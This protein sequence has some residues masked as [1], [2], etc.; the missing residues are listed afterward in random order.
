MTL[1]TSRLRLGPRAC[2]V[3]LIAAALLGAAS[4]YGAGDLSDVSDFG[5][6]EPAFSN[7]H[8]FAG[9]NQTGTANSARVDQVGLNGISVMQHGASNVALVSQAGQLNWASLSQSGMG[10]QFTASEFGTSNRVAATQSGNDNA[11]TVGQAGT[12]NRAQVVQIGNSNTANVQQ[13]GTNLGVAVR[14]T[15]NGSIATVVQH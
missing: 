2:C 12:A 3:P 5:P 7:G 10:N 1:K 15:G 9:I 6:P 11:A 4:A 14:Q 13:T 8:Q